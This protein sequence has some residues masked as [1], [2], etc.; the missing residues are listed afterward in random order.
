M[1]FT[2][3]SKTK[4]ITPGTVRPATIGTRTIAIAN[5][6]GKFYAFQNPCTHM[7]G[8]LSEGMVMGPVVVCPL[9]G[10]QFDITTG[11]RLSGP[12][13]RPIKTFK[14]KVDGD[15]VLVDLDE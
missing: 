2:F 11:E 1:A 15:N 9:H 4:D 12:T 6:G 5:V 3:A 14:I 8:H 13:N 7:G 10:C